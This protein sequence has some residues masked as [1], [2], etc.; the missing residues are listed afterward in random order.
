MLAYMNEESLQKTLATGQTWFYSRSRQELW[1]KGATS[2]HMQEVKRITYDCDGDALLLEVE[3][4]GGACH[5]GTVSCFFHTLAEIGEVPQENFLFVLENIIAEQKINRP[6]GSYTAKLFTGGLDRILKKIGEEAGEVI[7]AAKNRDRGEL[8]YESG[9][10]LFHLLVLLAE[11]GI[12]LAEVV[13]ELAR[14]H[15]R[16]RQSREERP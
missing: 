3:Q 1:H 2:G 10:L 8:I 15:G 7:I 4:T 9:D 12:T 16:G 11:K 14:R 5:T 13:A 6:T